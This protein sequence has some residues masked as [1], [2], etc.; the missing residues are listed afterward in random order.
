M[1]AYQ[2]YALCYAGP[3][4]GPGALTMWNRD[5]EARGQRAYYFWCLLGPGGPVVLD[6]GVG[7]Q[8][9]GERGLPGY[10]SPVELLARLGVEAAKVPHLVLSHLHWD[11]VGGA[12][13]F[14]AAQVHV[15]EAEWRFW[16]E[17]PVARRSVFQMLRDDQGLAALEAAQAQGRLR[18]HQGDAQ[19]LPGLELIA[20]PGHAPGLMALRA[21]AAAGPAVLGSDCGHTYRNYAEDWPSAFICDLPAW[22]RS[23]QRLRGLVQRPELLFPG[24]DIALSRDFPEV[25]PGVTRLA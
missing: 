3:L 15:Q 5:W 7:P 24:H 17:D 20:A 21:A 9:A 19:L 25:A 2:I 16:N 6:C 23:M 10:L 11:H 18:L 12:A 4:E 8:Q 1:D 13:L 14:P 22:L